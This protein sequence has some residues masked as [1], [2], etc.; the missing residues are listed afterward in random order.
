MTRLAIVIVNWN[1]KNLLE[2]CLRSIQAETQT[3]H[4]IWVVDNASS[5]GSREMVKERFPDVRLIENAENRGFAAANNQAIAQIQAPYILLLNS[6]TVVLDGALDRMVEH[7]ELHPELSAL[8]CRLLNADGTLQAS[9]HRFYSTMGSLVENKLMA[10]LIPWRFRHSPYLT[11]WDHSKNRQVDW[12]TGA[13][14]LVR[15]ATIEKVGL[16]DE[17]FFMYGEEVDWQLRMR[18]SGHKVGFLADA[19]I[20]HYG[21]ASAQKVYTTMNQH[22]LAGRA[23]LIR[24]HYHPLTYQIYLFKANLAKTYWKLRAG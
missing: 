2:E 20:I 14:L 6:D 24:K 10:R 11:F 4:C 1:T 19:Y 3:P 7:L 9:C 21:G 8:G 17:D 12:V 16:L 18:Q 13:C 23:R 22:E 5:D 15:K